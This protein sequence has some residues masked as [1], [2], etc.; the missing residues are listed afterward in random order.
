MKTGN[1]LLA[2]VMSLL[3]ATAGG[4]WA[5]ELRT[6]IQEIKDRSWLSCNDYRPYAGTYQYPEAPEAN[7][8]YLPMLAPTNA[9]VPATGGE[10]I[11]HTPYEFLV[12][13]PPGYGVPERR[14]PLIVLLTDRPGVDGATTELLQFV[15][16]QSLPFIVLVP[17]CPPLELW[18]T[19]ALKHCLDETLA[20][21]QVDPQRVYLT[22]YGSLGGFG[23]WALGCRYPDLFA[24]VAPVS[25][26]APLS[27]GSYHNREKE[28]AGVPVWLF[29]GASD[30]T[31]PLAAAQRQV[32]LLTQAGVNARLT[33]YP[34]LGHDLAAT[35]YRS[36]ALYDWFLKNSRDVAPEKRP[37][38]TDE[39]A[40]PASGSRQPEIV[41]WARGKA[42]AVA[43]TFDDGYASHAT[44]AGPLLQERGVRG[45]FFV[46]PGNVGSPGIVT[47]EQLRQLAAAGHEIA[48]H[49]HGY[50]KIAADWDRQMVTDRNL[51]DREIPQQRCVT[52][53]YG[54]CEFTATRA[55]ARH[56]IS[57]RR[58]VGLE[59][60][61]PGDLY[62]LK[63]RL[64]D[65]YSRA[66]FDQ[67]MVDAVAYH[68]LAVMGL[69]DTAKPDA[70][71]ALLDAIAAQSNALWVAPYRDVVAYI[72]ERRFTELRATGTQDAELRFELRSALP[73]DLYH[74]PVTLA[75]PLP[76]GWQNANVTQ[77]GK[78]VWSE[79]R[80][81]D[82]SL[83]C[84]AIPN[85]GELVLQK[86][87]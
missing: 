19:E 66:Q 52:H 57:G 47:W 43:L 79:F 62:A 17:R 39:P 42:A 14:W 83:L 67:L 18:Q 87:K 21:Y 41:Q 48:D 20:T 68:G 44:V 85:S 3:V 8:S 9:A 60:A 38:V 50:G 69:H 53:A 30:W 55:V 59:H 51:I 4:G 36:P 2:V 72:R 22:G 32:E 24:A 82:S 29:H 49:I 81:P 7:G 45:T 40:P 84:E 12:H 15:Q 25:G 16:T 23:A 70:L 75:V 71:R 33:T 74:Q 6:P 54:G 77:Q 86:S 78:P 28:L 56:F 46:M 1:L 65:G 13:L 58:C 37:R 27:G 76:A 63:C 73:K 61:E 64:C 80:S 26:L 10:F 11:R 5:E 31:V 34:G 35:V